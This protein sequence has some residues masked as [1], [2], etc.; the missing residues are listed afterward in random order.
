MGKRWDE[1]WHRLREWTSG[2]SP[3]ERLAVQI[4]LAEGFNEVDPSHP[5]GGKD[6]GK[7]AV[8]VRDGVHH[9]AGFYFPRGQQ[10]FAHIRAKFTS[11]LKAARER[12]DAEA[13][14]FVT[15]QELLLAERPLLE[16]AWPDHV[17]LYH[18]ERVTGILDQP[19]LASIRAQFLN[20]DEEPS[21]S[22]GDGGSGAIFGNRGTVIGGN[23]GRGGMGGSGGRGGSG[24]VFGDDGLVIGGDGGDAGSEDGRG[25]RGAR[26]PTERYGFETWKWGFGR[27]GGGPDAPEYTRRLGV[28][29][30]IRQEYLDKFA[31]DAPYILAGIDV[32]PV[33]WLNQRL[34]E[35]GEG[36][37]VVWGKEGYVLPPLPRGVAD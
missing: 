31:E 15:N 6:G 21:A 14:V 36:W 30:Q 10:S 17:T 9:I 27:G 18:L 13:F 1:T 24:T 37:H 11:D 32:V 34:D 28:L 16:A 29:I 8:C 19:A 33:A 35:L 3:A 26:G 5:L 12:N 4:L 7:D 22:G 20:I 2:Q 25:G 23:A